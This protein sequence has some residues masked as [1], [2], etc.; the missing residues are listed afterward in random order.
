MK[1]KKFDEYNE[2]FGK[3][4]K[5]FFG[6]SDDKKEDK[7]LPE[8]KPREKRKGCYCKD[9]GLD[10]KPSD[11]NCPKC[12]SANIIQNSDKLSKM[13]PSEHSTKGG[14]KTYK[15]ARIDKQTGARITTKKESPALFISHGN[16]IVQRREFDNESDD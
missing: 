2:S 15:N 10:C 8:Y 14:T 12:D 3:N 7:P 1:I 6:F 4:I 11:S 9:C 5:K 13:M 16:R